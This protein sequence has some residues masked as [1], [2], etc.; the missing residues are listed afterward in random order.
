MMF[1]PAAAFVP[2]RPTLT[3]GGS[4]V[5][6]R[7][8]GSPGAFAKSPAFQPPSHTCLSSAVEN[9]SAQ[10]VFEPVVN[11]PALGSFLFIAIVFSFLIA[12]VRAVEGAV[13]RR[14]AAL[15]QLRQVKS[16]ELSSGDADTDTVAKALKE[17]ENALQSE[18]DLRT[19][20]P[21]VRIVA[22]N[23]PAGSNEEDVAAARQF[24]GIDLEKTSSIPKD[25]ERKGL[26]AGS[27]AVLA[28]VALSQIAL[29]YM[30]S[31]DPME[32]YSTL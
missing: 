9:S 18:E 19:L 8:N 5:C 29:L 23:Q 10:V 28:V 21:G 26:S 20:I 32:T 1:V 14:K 13:E 25:E 30:L 3:P 12:R 27:V 16:M 2:C 15:A 24:L 17:Y 7:H 6:K 11:V 4:S 22:P 31:F